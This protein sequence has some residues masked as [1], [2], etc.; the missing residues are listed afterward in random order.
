MFQVVDRTGQVHGPVP[1]ETLRN[2]AS[3]GR[4]TPD[5]TVIN[6]ATGQQGPAGQM[7][8]GTLVFPAQA[9]GP[10]GPAAQGPAPQAPY[11]A[12]AQPQQPQPVAQPQPVQQ[13]YQNAQNFVQG[14][15]PQGNFQQ[16][17]A[18]Y[19][20]QGSEAAGAIPKI[21]PRAT[22]F[23][24]DFLLGMGIS[25]VFTSFLSLLLWDYAARGFNLGWTGYLSYIS[26]PLVA[27]F[28][29]CKDSFLSGQSVG[30]RIAR[31]KV[32]GPTGQPCTLMQSAMRNIW[33]LPMVLL[34]I[35]YV[36]GFVVMPI[37]VIFLLVE[38]FM[39]LTTGK[40]VM[41]GPARTLVVNE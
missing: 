39:V 27:L 24:V 7:L 31:I 21:G 22:A 6:P 36:G 20:F 28:F 8:A 41:D 19:G 15:I 38:T 29:L 25:G 5:M 12:P 37:V 4:L 3:E 33:A 17:A 26:A 9:G 34:P 23:L 11:Q 32:I 18:Q 35:P 10:P 40:H 13:A 14:Q 2:W 16:P 30:K 1:V